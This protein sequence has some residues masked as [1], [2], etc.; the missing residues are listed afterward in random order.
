[1]PMPERTESYNFL[2]R[3][4]HDIMFDPEFAAT[5]NP[6]QP[7]ELLQ[8][9][10]DDISVDSLVDRMLYL[11]WK[12]TLADND[13]RKVGRMCSLAGVEVRF[14][15]LDDDVIELSTRIPGDVKMPGTRLRHFVKSTLTGFLPDE[16][17]NKSKH[18][19]GLP[20]GEWLK[21][22]KRLQELTY[23]LLLRFRHQRIV[24]A[25]FIDML[26]AEHRSGHAAYYGTMV[27]VMAMLQAWLDAHRLSR[28]K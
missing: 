2:N 13:L 1:M 26:I 11:D 17:I 7:L 15:W 4:S 14:P 25:D 28:V 22:S 27:W 21:T 23:D 3:Q 9:R 6:G 24:R 19:F 5:L 10:Y 20:F 16:I 18:G 12:F 8:S